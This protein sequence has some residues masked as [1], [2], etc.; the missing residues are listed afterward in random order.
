MRLAVLAA[1]VFVVAPARSQDST[2]ISLADAVALA[3]EESPDVRRAEAADR[4]RALAV[5]AARAGRLPDV[6]FQVAPQQRYGLGFDQTTGEVVSQTVE[7]LGLSAQASLPLYDGGRTSALVREARF[8]VDAAEAG[9]ERTRQQVALDVVQ[10][11][12][13]LLL[14]RE[15]V[16]IE[17]EGLA[18]ARA[19]L[20]RVT[21]LVEAGARPR[22]DVFAQESVVAQRRTALVVAEGATLHRQ[23]QRQLR[24]QKVNAVGRRHLLLLQARS[25]LALEAGHHVA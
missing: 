5:R 12:L 16:G 18:A 9:L 6:A 3:L 22:G 11:F 14:D 10:Q 2:A 25:Q 1:L 7:T 24:R 17:R 13:T 8:R 20:E 23:P 4:G 21:E 15:I 19:Q